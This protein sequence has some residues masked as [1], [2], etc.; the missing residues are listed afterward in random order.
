MKKVRITIVFDEKH[1][2]VLNN[3]PADIAQ[4]RLLEQV[5]LPGCTVVEYDNALV[6]VNLEAIKYILMENEKSE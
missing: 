5:G 6:S 4:Y 2:L 1:N 3:I